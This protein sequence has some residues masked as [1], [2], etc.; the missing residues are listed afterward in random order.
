MTDYEILINSEVFKEPVF[1]QLF[2]SEKIIQ[3]N[4]VSDY[5]ILVRNQAAIWSNYDARTQL[6]NSKQR[7]YYN[8]TN[9]N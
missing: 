1:F 5:E 7:Q 9:C 8:P 3:I 2:P 6:H 4:C